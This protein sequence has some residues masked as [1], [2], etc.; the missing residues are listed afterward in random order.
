MFD[1]LTSPRR[2][3]S[4]DPLD[5]DLH[6]EQKI[7]ATE[8]AKANR[9]SE[10]LERN[11]VLPAINV[12]KQVNGADDMIVKDLNT[13]RLLDERIVRINLLFYHTIY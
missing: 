4:R 12:N 1:H 13:E 6:R 10:E 11:E 8:E 5:T 7:V 3:R 9:R 2:K